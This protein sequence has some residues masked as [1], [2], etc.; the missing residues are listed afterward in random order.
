MTEMI[1]EV[2]RKD[3][4]DEFNIRSLKYFHQ[5]CGGGTV[6][7]INYSHEYRLFCKRCEAEGRISKEVDDHKL[8]IIHAAINGTEYT[9]KRVSGIIRF[10]PRPVEEEV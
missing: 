6:E 9:V 2:E 1:I 8:G 7:L 3:K 10:V 4:K 5:N